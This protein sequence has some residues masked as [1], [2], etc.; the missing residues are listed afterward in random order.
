MEKSIVLI[1]GAT[2]GLGSALSHQLARTR[3]NLLLID[4]SPRSLDLLSDEIVEAGHD[5]PGVCPLDFMAAGSAEFC[6]ISDILE[7]EY[8]GLDCLIHCAA[9]FDALRPLEQVPDEQWSECMQVN[10]NAARQLTIHCLPLI[11]RSGRGTVVFVQDEESRM[12]AP[13]W[14][15][16][17]ASKAAL[18]NFGMMA[19]AELE[20]T[21]VRI[22][23]FTPPPMRTP[24]R[25]RAYLSEAPESLQD[26]DQVD[27]EMIVQLG[28]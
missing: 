27:R 19:E 5:E 4:R 25:A 10:F 6:S 26:P 7:Q 15:A 13:Y 20:G 14:G 18:Q 21:G 11:R 9:T 17:G 16:Y 23:N 28:I 24:L 2:G 1:T 12:H 22:L 3:S 8:G